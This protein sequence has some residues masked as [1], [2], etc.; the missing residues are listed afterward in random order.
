[1][2]AGQRQL[3]TGVVVNRHCN[4]ARGEFDALKAILFNCVRT[5]PMAQNRRGA[6]DFRRHLD[7]RVAWVEQLNPSRGAKLRRLFEQIDWRVS[8]TSIASATAID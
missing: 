2:T 8:E 7:G 1:M 6:P 3:V 5:G 4:L